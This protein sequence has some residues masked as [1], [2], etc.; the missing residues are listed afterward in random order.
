MFPVAITH[1]MCELYSPFTHPTGESF[2][3]LLTQMVTVFHG[4][5]NIYQRPNGP[6]GPKGQRARR[7]KGPNGPKDPKGQRTR[8]SKGPN[9]PRGPKGPMGRGAQRA[10]GPEGPKGPMGQGT[11]RAKGPKKDDRRTTTTDWSSCVVVRRPSSSSVS[12]LC[13]PSSVVVVRHVVLCY[14]TGSH[15]RHWPT[16]MVLASHAHEEPCNITPPCWSNRSRALF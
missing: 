9:G 1:R 13:H 15:I 4:S 10:K 8:R 14:A 5:Q 7:S 6:K 2:S 16:L 12:C 3:L 11:Q